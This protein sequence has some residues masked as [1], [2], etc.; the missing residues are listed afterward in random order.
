VE[1]VKDVLVLMLERL[2]GILLLVMS[3]VTFAQVLCRY[4]FII[5]LPWA[6]ELVTLIFIWAV[7]LSVPIGVDRMEH[8]SVTFFLSHRSTIRGFPLTLVHFPMAIVFFLVVLI[9]SF[10]VVEAFEGMRLLSI[11][12]PINARYY[13]AIVGSVITIFLL[14]TK[15]Y[16]LMKEG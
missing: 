8:L 12:V 4:V 16:K 15:I 6:H 1:K 5:S 13:A 3:G 11:P 14:G 7:W 2:V 9:L 10:T